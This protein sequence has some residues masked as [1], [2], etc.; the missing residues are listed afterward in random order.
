ME[1]HTG[2]PGSRKRAFWGTTEASEA[3]EPQAKYPSNKLRVTGDITGTDDNYVISNLKSDVDGHQLC[4]HQPRPLRHQYKGDESLVL[5]GF[6]GA[7]KRTLGFIASVALRREFVDFDAIF[8]RKTKLSRGAY[9]A[10]HGPKAYRIVEYEITVE[11]L[12]T[13]KEGC[14]LAGFFMMADRRQC[15]LLHELSKTNP[16]IHVMRDKGDL[17]DSLGHDRGK[18]EHA[19]EISNRLCG[20]YSNFDYFNM[21]QQF[22][23]NAIGPLKL[24]QTEQDFVRFI[25]GVFNQRPCLVRSANA[26]SRSYTYALQVPAAWLD[27]SDV[28]LTEL[29]S[30]ADSINL[31]FDPSFAEQK[32]L[33]SLSRQIAVLRRHT[34]V[35]II[36]DIHVQ[37]GLEQA[38]HADILQLAL[39]QLPDM[40]TV[41]LDTDYTLV[42][43]LSVA[44]CHT[45]I[46]GTTQLSD[47]WPTEKDS[48]RWQIIYDKANSL[49]C[50][51]VRI[52]R[53]PTSPLENLDCINFMMRI[54]QPC[55]IPVMGYNV[56]LIGITS[57][58]FSPTLSPVVLS[59]MERD[60][61]T[62]KQAQ[63]ALYSSFTLRKKRFA[64]FGQSL[65]Y[66]LS[67]T[68]HNAAYRACGMPHSCY[69]AESNQFQ[70]INRLLQNDE[71]GG[72]AIALP[73]K[74]QFLSILDEMTPDVRD[75]GAVNTVVVDRQHDRDGTLKTFLKGY[76]TD[77][78]GVRICMERNL[79]PANVITSETSVL[80][81]GAGGI[82]RAA[83]YAC[84]QAGVRKICIFNRTSSNARHLAERFRQWATSRAS[85]PLHIVVLESL[86]APWPSNM[87]QPTIIMSCRPAHEIGGQ[88]P[89][90]FDIPEQWLGSKTGGVFIE[91]AY[92][93]LVTPLMKQMIQRSSRGWI[94][95]DGLD[96]LV[97][98][99]IAQFEILT[100]R[101]AP[102]HVMKRAVRE[103]YQATRGSYD[104]H[105]SG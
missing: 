78:M 100:G 60:G 92:E 94:V 103:Q 47:R 53:I 71:I 104:R 12:R 73:Y 51:A 46:I 31:I 42:D 54:I 40:I 17:L 69:T 45:K 3:G 27:R 8:E 80:I 7:G 29:D 55:E 79:S 59:S 83:I 1:H 38:R 98:Q 97:E 61:V 2:L 63:H 75:I 48:L 32:C 76:N 56:G 105:N 67:P 96:V 21:T 64:I 62:L 66:S 36:L 26:L 35:P 14:V 65:S 23:P 52:T 74:V 22:T 5:V 4:N 43:V 37:N 28:D 77:H 34:R 20:Q 24:K 90:A 49:G 72:L 81:L 9:I 50:D 82:A 101:P 93:P 99:G 58:C 91:L 6:W 25:R 44:K 86:N 18:A 39:R 95:V 68:M 30:G 89:P 33:S 41:S 15:Q 13:K 19:Y 11:V 85:T 57:V 16:V 10:S 102:V 87:S 88:E 84:Y 70:D